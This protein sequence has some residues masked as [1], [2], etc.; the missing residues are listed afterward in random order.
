MSNNGK[1]SFRPASR[2]PLVS[3]VLDGSWPPSRAASSAGVSRRTVFSR[4]RLFRLQAPGGLMDRSSQ[5][6]FSHQRTAAEIPQGVEE[7]RR[8]RLPSPII[9]R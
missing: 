8:Q 5:P 1:A 3:R 6:G 2:S 4:L 9:N 7:L